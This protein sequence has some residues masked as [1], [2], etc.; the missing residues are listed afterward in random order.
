VL[1]VLEVVPS[2]DSTGALTGAAIEIPRAGSRADA[3][4]L[5]VAGWV[6]GRASR[7][8]EIEVAH[9]GRVIRRS[10]VQV[11]RPDI[12]AAHPGA[13]DA[14]SCGF[15]ELVGVLGLTREF[16]LRVGAVLEG[17]GDRVELGSIR[18]RR[19]PLRTGY[20]PALRPLMVS[21]LGRT[22]TT[23]LMKM[24]ASH[25]EIVVYR[26]YPYESSPAKYWMHL[27][28]VLSEPS[29]FVDSSHPDSFLDDI[30]EIG[31]NPFF[32]YGLA[33]PEQADLYD[34]VARDYV[35]QLGL[36]CQRSIDQ[37]YEAV[38]RSQGQRRAVYFAEK[39]MWPGHV[40]NLTWELYPEG[41]ELFLV[42]DF[43]DMVLSIIA[44]DRKRGFA[45]FRRPSGKSDEAYI[46]EDLR[47][48]VLGFRASWEE[49][50]ERAHLVRYEDMV[51]RPDETLTGLLEYLELDRSPSLVAGMHAAAAEGGDFHRT[52]PDV[53]ASIG[54]W[55]READDS[56]RDLCQEVFEDVLTEFGYSERVRGG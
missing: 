34:W 24:L 37:W 18:A 49:R 27:L 12:A 36:F 51:L 50:K 55:E 11:P 43:R 22:G 53:E 1:E 25:P 44:F 29:N 33:L 14:A 32:D 7:A 4:V 13:A 31:Y 21:C 23:L 16:E 38:A 40:P 30:W 10:P 6:L 3:Y 39:H 9:E 54:R 28:R 42:R 5:H 56:F 52:S 47:E 45:G 26:R 19:E 15:E 41:K 20:R 8:V 35:R 48:A 17:E 46:R 2:V